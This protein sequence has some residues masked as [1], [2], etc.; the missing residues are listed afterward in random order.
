MALSL[1]GAASGNALMLLALPLIGV[2]NAFAMFTAINVILDVLPPSETGVGAALTRTLGQIGSSFG[3]AIMGSLLNGAYRAELAGHLTGLPGQLKVV[4]E[5]SVAGAGFVAG[6]LP[7]PLGGY[8]LSAA[9]DAYATGM[10]EALRGSAGVIV[11]AACLVAL[12]MPGR[13]L[14]ARRQSGDRKSSPAQV[15][16]GV[17]AATEE[18]S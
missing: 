18:V 9:R 8:F 14:V 4:A 6:H 11:V 15:V 2:G 17:P 10:S 12:F 5:D 16:E 3:V 13:V 7:A 1:V